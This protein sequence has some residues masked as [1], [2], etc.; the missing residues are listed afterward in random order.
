[1]YSAYTPEYIQELGE[2]SWFYLIPCEFPVS[3][4]IILSFKRNDIVSTASVAE[5]GEVRLVLNDGLE[6]V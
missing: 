5:S 4:G 3:I 6:R 1:V 2:F